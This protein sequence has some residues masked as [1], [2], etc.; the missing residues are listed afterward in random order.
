MPDIIK[1][2]RPDLELERISWGI[3][4]IGDKIA[5]TAP[6]KMIAGNIMAQSYQTASVQSGRDTAAASSISASAATANLVSYSCVEKYSRKYMG[7]TQMQGFGGK[8]GAEHALAR[9][10]KRAWKKAHETDVATA[11][12][13]TSASPVD[14]SEDIISAID[15]A[16]GS[17]GELTGGR[18]ALVIPNNIFVAMKKNQ[19]IIARMQATGVGLGD[20][21]ARQFGP[22]QFAAIFGVDECLIGHDSVWY[23]AIDSGLRNRIAVVALPDDGILPAEEPQYART[24]AYDWDNDVV[25]Y[26]IEEWENP[27]DD[28]LVM[29]AKGLYVVKE[30][31]TAFKVVI[32]T[33]A[34]SSSSSSSSASA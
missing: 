27:F 8:T 11:L 29:D 3:D 32:S 15:S 24:V 1:Q 28:T 13:T 20:I 18:R 7:Y 2:R 16:V 30:F 22:E 14:G 19:N 21:R 26:I 12:L 34:S 23:T 5:P 25:S 6:V 31:N 4:Y 9:M 33:A 17:I 10:V